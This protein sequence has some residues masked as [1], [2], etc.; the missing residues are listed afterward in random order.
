MTLR[1]SIQAHGIEAAVHEGQ[2]AIRIGR[3][4]SPGLTRRFHQDRHDRRIASQREQAYRRALSRHNH[5][6][7]ALTATLLHHFYQEHRPG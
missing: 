5:H 7:T 4:V 3:R 1:F 6:Q 2:T